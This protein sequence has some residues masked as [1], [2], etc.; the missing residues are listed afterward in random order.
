MK[1]GHGAL[2]KKISGEVCPESFS[3][4]SHLHFS[5]TTSVFWMFCVS[6]VQAL[7]RSAGFKFLFSTASAF[8]H[9]MKQS[10]APCAAGQSVLR[11][12]TR[13]PLRKSPPTHSTQ[14]HPLLT[15]TLR[16]QQVPK[17]FTIR[18]LLSYS[19]VRKDGRNL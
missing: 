6:T 19:L 11:T 9:T 7:F 3:V 10:S 1:A 2:K 12:H 16:F 17:S 18:I 4:Y 5:Q 8:R 13:H 15:Q 14:S